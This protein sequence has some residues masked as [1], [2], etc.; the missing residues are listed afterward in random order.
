MQIDTESICSKLKHL[1]TN[2][3]AKKDYE[4]SCSHATTVSKELVHRA[5]VSEV[6]LTDV[7]KLGYDRFIT[8]AH[9]PR[10][11]SYYNDIPSEEKYYDNIL[12]LEV[13]RQSSIIITHNYYDVPL[14]AKFIFNEAKFT[15][16]NFNALRIKETSSNLLTEVNVISEDKRNDKLIGLTFE[17]KV[18]ID[19]LLCATKLMDI[20]WLEAALWKKIRRKPIKDAEEMYSNNS[21][22]INPSL[23]LEEGKL[24]GRGSFSNVVIYK[25]EK[26]EED[27]TRFK[28][29]V[30]EYHPAIFD[31]PLDHI[32]GMLIIESFR[33]SSIR[34]L[35]DNY[36]LKHDEIYMKV[37]NIDFVKFAELLL[38]TYCYIE[39][40]CVDEI[41]NDIKMV[42]SVRQ[43]NSIS[44]LVNITYS[45]A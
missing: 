30:N 31:H 44:A 40:V 21:G 17:M 39:N 24:V 33:Q 32:P 28:I 34:F 42:L 29:F 7:N 4:S 15:I 45:G 37:I 11:H 9:L 13:C 27:K 41:T 16:N 3:L 8:G 10:T 22:A 1:E 19:G 12:L 5:A 38:D 14:S 6:F 23:E 35:L 18:Y 26:A 2:M 43:N 36:G 20:T 25:P